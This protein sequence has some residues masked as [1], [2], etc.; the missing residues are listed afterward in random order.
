[1]LQLS[2]FP[3]AIDMTKVDPDQNMHRFYRMIIIPDLFGGTSLCRQW[4]CIGSP[5]RLTYKFYECEGQAVTA[6]AEM[7]RRKVQRGYA[8]RDQA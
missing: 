8:I 4:G 3:C 7:A 1:M 6:L 5:G 2:L